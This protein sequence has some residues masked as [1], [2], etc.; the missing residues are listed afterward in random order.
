MDQ[1]ACCGNMPV[2]ALDSDETVLPVSEMVDIA[3]QVAEGM[4]Y[5]QSQ[6]FV[7]RDLA[8][9]NILVGRNNICKVGDFGL[10]RL[11][12]VRS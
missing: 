7:H 8:A 9:R 2:L 12:K 11:I 10:A 4:C 5:L 3:S 6:N 1:A